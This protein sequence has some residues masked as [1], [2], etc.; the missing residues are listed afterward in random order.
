MTAQFLPY[1]RDFFCHNSPDTVYLDGGTW[2]IYAIK[3]AD[4]TTIAPGLG[5]QPTKLC[6]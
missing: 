1:L 3:N 2:A 4:I 6:S 5:L